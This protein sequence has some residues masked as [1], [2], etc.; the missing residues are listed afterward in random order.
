MCLPIW[1]SEKEY[2]SIMNL[3]FFKDKV[4]CMNAYKPIHQARPLFSALILLLC[5]HAWCMWMLC[6][7]VWRQE[8]DSRELLPSFKFT[9][10]LNRETFTCWAATTP[11]PTS[12][13]SKLSLH[14][15][16]RHVW[17]TLISKTNEQ[18]NRNL[19]GKLAYA[20]FNCNQKIASIVILK[21][22]IQKKWAMFNE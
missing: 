20:L 9:G 6:W 5:M 11:P 12:K 19:L 14:T 17:G 22:W 8:D 10:R 3:I 18:T 16:T 1:D 4:K 21:Q 13:T 15:P 2:L 7:C